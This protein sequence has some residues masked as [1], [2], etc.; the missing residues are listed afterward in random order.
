MS[1]FRYLSPYPEYWDGCIRG[2]RPF[3]GALGW[4]YSGISAF[5]GAL[6]WWYLKIGAF[7]ECIGMVVFGDCGLF[8][9]QWDGCI[10]R[11]RRFLGALGW[12]YLGIAAFSGCIGMVVFGDCSLFWVHLDSCQGLRPFLGISTITFCLHVRANT[13]MIC[14][15]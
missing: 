8:W 6:G 3:L 4:L 5:S 9:V 11:L 13:A 1:Y 15:C 14:L 10:R 7:S 2:L 12:L